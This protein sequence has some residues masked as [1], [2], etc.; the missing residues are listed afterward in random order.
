[1]ITAG[2]RVAGNK[3]GPRLRIDPT[4][5]GTDAIPSHRG[6]FET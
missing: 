1:M 6:R 3:D 4:A 2:L 5:M